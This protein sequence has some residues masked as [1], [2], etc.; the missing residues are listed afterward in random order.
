MI[1]REYERGEGPHERPQATQRTR[2]TTYV[3]DGAEAARV[4]M[5]LERERMASLPAPVGREPG[6]DDE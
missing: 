4:A 6:E 1:R 2:S 3:K 5:R